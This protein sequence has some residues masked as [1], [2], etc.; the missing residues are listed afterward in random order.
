MATGVAQDHQGARYMGRLRATRMALMA[1]GL[2][3]ELS[4]C[5]YAY[6]DMRR[7]TRVLGWLHR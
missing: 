5:C 2:G 1:T 3:L 4:V 6:R 7:T